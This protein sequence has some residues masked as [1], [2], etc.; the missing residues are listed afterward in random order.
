[1]ENKFKNETIDINLFHIKDS[2]YNNACF[3]QSI[4]NSIFNKNI[5]FNNN[6]HK[7]IQ[8]LSYEWII[9]NKN[10]Y[11]EEFGLKVNELVNMCHEI[12]IDTYEKTYKYYA[13]EF[14][15]DIDNRW[16]SLIEAIAI[17]EIFKISIFIFPSIV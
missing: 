6:L 12:D 16:G 3:Y 9:S 14:I 7:L 4:S 8:K 2:K 10:K 1:M 13:D 17:S 11:I 5:I 15:E